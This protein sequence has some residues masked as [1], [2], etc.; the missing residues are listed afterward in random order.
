MDTT[1][2]PVLIR[3]TA[4]R[5]GGPV[6]AFGING[7]VGTTELP[8]GPGHTVRWDGS[9]QL[10]LPVWHGGCRSCTRA[11]NNLVGKPFPRTPG[12]I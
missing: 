1:N 12:T 4:S 2:D 10:P 6:A 8:T 9:Y 3:L 7:G 5:P 11:P